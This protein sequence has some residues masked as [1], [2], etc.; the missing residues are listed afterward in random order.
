VASFGLSQSQRF[1]RLYLPAAIPRLVYNSILSW[2]N[3]WFFLV[4]CEIIAVG[5]VKYNLPG[6][7]SFLA[8]AAEQENIPLVLWGIAALAAVILFLDFLVWKP[9]MVWSE[10]FRQDNT[11]NQ[12]EEDVGIFLNLP[13]TLASRLQLGK[14]NSSLV[15]PHHKI[16][17]SHE[18]HQINDA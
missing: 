18:E 1:L 14:M 11:A 2:S 6:I 3:G 16:D 12:D 8:K 4:A 9:L 15:D 13:K 10:R 5:P 17:E 7:G